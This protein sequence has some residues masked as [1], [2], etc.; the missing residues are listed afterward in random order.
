MSNLTVSVDDDTYRRS[1]IRAAELGTVD[2]S[3]SAL[4]RTILRSLAGDFGCESGAAA[5]DTEWSLELWR[6]MLREA[7]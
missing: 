7:A 6:R 2:P 3:V 1:R 5:R 4:V